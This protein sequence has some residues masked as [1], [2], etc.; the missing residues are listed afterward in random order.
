MLFHIQSYT[1]RLNIQT[2][3]RDVLRSLRLNNLTSILCSCQVWALRPKPV[4]DLWLVSTSLDLL[5]ALARRSF[6]LGVPDLRHS[7][8]QQTEFGVVFGSLHALSSH[9]QKVTCSWL[10]VAPNHGAAPLAS[11]ST[12]VAEVLALLLT[13]LKQ[14][15]EKVWQFSWVL[16]CPDTD[17]PSS[18]WAT[19]K[20]KEQ[21]H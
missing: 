5:S 13:E 3:K 9:Q 4:L 19:V 21:L 14:I 15:L 11:G 1:H 18:H 7:S 12:L 6:T 2:R 16:A 8:S 10:Q 20:A 17:G